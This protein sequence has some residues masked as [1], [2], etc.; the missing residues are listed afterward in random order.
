ML[1][2]GHILRVLGLVGFVVSVATAGTARAEHRPLLPEAELGEDGLHKQP[3]FH[4]SFLDLRDDLAEAAASG[5]RLLVM[6]EQKGCPYCE[7]THKVNLR[8]PDIVDYLKKNFLVLQLNLWGDR[9]VTDLDGEAI[10]EKKLAMKWGV[11]YTPTMTFLPP[12]IEDAKG[13]SGKDAAVHTLFGYFYPFHYMTT[14][15]YVVERGYET[16]PNF[17]RFLIAKGQAI[18]EKGGHVDFFSPH[19]P[20]I[21]KDG[22]KH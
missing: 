1:F 5:K 14:L 2:W 21:P 13:Q 9:E 20:E 3:W 22:K 16:E 10:S 12:T 4:E 6:W 15:Q 7:K 17:Q 8:N 19:L 18:Q 11:R